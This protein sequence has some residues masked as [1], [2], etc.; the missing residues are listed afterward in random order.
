MEQYIRTELKS[1]EAYSTSK[2]PKTLSGIPMNK[3]IKLDANENPYGCSPRVTEA[4]AN[5]QKFNIYT[6]VNQ[7]EIRRLLANYTGVS[8][9]C[10][11]A[12]SGSNVLLDM[13]ARLFVGPG[14]GVINCVPTFD[15]YRFSTQICGGR[16]IEVQ[17]DEAYAIDVPSVKAAVDKTIKLIFLANPNAPTGNL[18]PEPDLREI[19]DLGL[20]TV[21]DE[22]Y[23][24][25]S[26]VT[27]IPLMQEYPNLMIIR[28]FSKWAGLAGL[29]VGY[30]LFPTNIA[31]YLHMIK[32][33]Y[34]VN[35]AALV[36]V[37]ESMKDLDYLRNNVKTIVT[38]R[39]RLFSELVK[40]DWLK[41]FP[42]QANYILCQLLEGRADVLQQKLQD[43]G[44]LVR[45]FKKPRLDNCIRISIGRPEDNGAV[46]RA[47]QEI[48]A[49]T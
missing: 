36:A 13:V 1:F 14:D 11:V 34:N 3:I 21:I 18:T 12:S 48:E 33:P 7:T 20:P 28:T 6:D 45:Y 37:S 23:Y 43:R 29:R 16:L 17:R 8:A 35:V 47:L 2:D 26:G 40:I 15:I 9:D 49:G 42:S 19:L 25:F 31:A 24:E 44:I 27:V 46:I 10:I 5:Y 22:A 39:E 4:L 38:E 30:G 32:I 41:P